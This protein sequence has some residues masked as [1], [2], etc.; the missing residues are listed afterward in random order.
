MPSAV[1][2]ILCLVI[3][4]P[5]RLCAQATPAQ[6]SLQNQI[7]QRLSE[8]YIRDMGNRSAEYQNKIQES[9]DK[10]LDKLKNQELILKQQLSKINTDEANRIFEGTEHI[11]S[12]LQN[13]LNTDADNVLKSCGKY[14]PGID[15]AITS[16]KFLQN[17]PVSDKIT[18]NIAQVKGAMSKVKS[19]EDQFKK[20]D[21]VEEFI[22]QR[23]EYLKAQ[24]SSYQLPGLQQYN[25]QAAYYA[26]QVNELKE[27][28]GDPSHA[29]QKAISLL[30]KL[31]AFQ[32][33]MKKNSAI[34]GLFNLPDDYATSGLSGLQTKDQVQKLMQES[35]KMMG[36]N[37][38]QTAQQSIGDA[39]TSLSSLRDKLNRGSSELAMPPGQGNDQHTRS[40][41]KRITYGIDV[42]S[43]RSN[44]YF[45]SQTA[46]ALTAGYKINERNTIGIGLSYTVGWGKD[47]Q[48]VHITNQG[49]GF[50]SF[51]DFKIIG[52]L[53][54]TGG[55]E[56]N[57]AY[58]FISVRQLE[59]SG[60]WQKSGLIGIT[61][62]VSIRSN[63]VKKTKL[64]LLWNFLSYYQVPQTQPF[65]FRV[66]YNIN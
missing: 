55:F 66:G 32:E 50:R 42:Q 44:V 5:L 3:F 26:Q 12:K 65:I 14:V 37:G 38:A 62:M 15:S 23:E 53:Y 36:P 30:N 17:S 59:V 8:K 39:Q 64:Q 20:A 49:I 60:L 45:P 40:F 35:M 63:M 9:T 43:T 47:I 13:D 6:D 34:A 16:L 54:A 4:V 52:S 25:Q 51:G 48:H 58:P 1:T 61:K 10:Y 29:E 28:W 41:L 11:Y 46:F 31:P 33:F 21:N 56:Y 57:Y 22:K 24:L 2:G 19:L 18:N 7:S 27:A